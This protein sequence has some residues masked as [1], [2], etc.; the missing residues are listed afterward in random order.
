[1]RKY[2]YV[3]QIIEEFQKSPDVIKVVAIPDSAYANTNS[4]RCAYRRA[5]KTLKYNIV[6]RM[7]N[8]DMYLIKVQNPNW[9]VK[10]HNRMCFS[11]ANRWPS[12][13]CATCD[14]LSN[15]KEGNV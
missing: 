14:N 13:A 2:G 1:M 6:T 8:G 15:Y 7:I 12:K 3:Q 10:N 9:T 5:I 4:A 11:C